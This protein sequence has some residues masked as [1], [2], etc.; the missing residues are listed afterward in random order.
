M[1]SGLAGLGNCKAGDG[2][3]MDIAAEAAMVAA[4]L[5]DLETGLK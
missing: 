1:L 3:D 4:G 2:P 5:V